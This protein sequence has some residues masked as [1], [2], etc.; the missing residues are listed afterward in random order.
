MRVLTALIFAVAAP[1]AQ[2]ESLSHGRFKNVQIYRPAGI[3]KQVALFLSGDGGWDRGTA[4]MAT[5]LATGGTLVVGI[6]SPRFFAALEA[7]GGTCVFPDGDL[8]NLS[9]FV[10]AYYKLPTYFTPLLIGYSAGASLAYATLAQAPRGI[11]GGALSLS[12]CADLDLSKPLCKA[13]SLQ[14]SPLKG[15]ARVSR[16]R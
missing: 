13:E 16:R 8:E 4:A 11:F 14:Y 12:F 9:H 7:D 5:E 2:A 6:D 15:M 10:Q 3:V 1:L